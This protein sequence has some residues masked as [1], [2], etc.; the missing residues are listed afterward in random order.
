MNR[1]FILI[2]LFLLSGCDTF[3]GVSRSAYVNYALDNNCIGR[4]LEQVPE[5]SNIEYQYKE[6]G[7]PLTLSGIQKPD[8]VHYYHYKTGDLN[9]YVYLIINYENESNIYQSYGT[10]HAIIPQKNI[11]IIRPIMSKIDTAVSE[12]CNLD[13]EFKESCSGVICEELN[14]L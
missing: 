3:Y 5:L 8:Q 4:A 12:S 2:L 10:L 6:G 11:D 7:K 1:N 13:I 14:P 9:G